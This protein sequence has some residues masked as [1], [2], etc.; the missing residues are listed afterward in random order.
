MFGFV[1]ALS[2][3]LLLCNS[4]YTGTAGGYALCYAAHVIWKIGRKS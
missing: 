2:V 3:F 1:Q 4:G